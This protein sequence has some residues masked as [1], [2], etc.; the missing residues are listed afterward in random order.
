VL[1]VG[2]RAPDFTTTDQSGATVSLD[3]LVRDN[4]VVLYFYPRDFTPVCTAQACTFRDAESELAAEGARVVGVSAD[5]G[6]SH[7]RFATKHRVGFT[8][9]SDPEKALQKAFGA[10]QLLGLLA[11]RVTYVIDRN[12]TVRGVFHHELSAE[13]HLDAVRKVLKSLT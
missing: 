6:D 10:R 2:D 12:K 7:A 5:S 3:D 1:A 4:V 11:K 13:K 8:L 9:L